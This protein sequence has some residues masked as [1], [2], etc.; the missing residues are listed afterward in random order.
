MGE[1]SRKWYWMQKVWWATLTCG[2]NVVAY[3]TVSDSKGGTVAHFPVDRNMHL[4][5]DYYCMI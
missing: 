1:G 2:I 3:H 4:M 5:H